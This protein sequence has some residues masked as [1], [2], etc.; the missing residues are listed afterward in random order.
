ML[1]SNYLS[2][3]NAGKHLNRSQDVKVLSLYA[4]RCSSIFEPFWFLCLSKA[5][6]AISFVESANHVARRKPPRS[7]RS[8]VMV[9]VLPNYTGSFS[10]LMITHLQLLIFH[11]EYIQVILWHYCR[12]DRTLTASNPFECKGSF[13]NLFEC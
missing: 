1:W 12:N 5:C 3:T 13:E 9:A 6:E 2:L 11:L 10:S 8:I 4:T 7:D